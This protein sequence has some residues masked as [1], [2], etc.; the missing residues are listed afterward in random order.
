MDPDFG[1]VGKALESYDRGILAMHQGEPALAVDAFADAIGNDPDRPVLW[2]WEAR[3][4]ITAGRIE[5]AISR[6]NAGL[7]RF[8]DDVVLRYQRAAVLAKS[9]NLPASVQDLRWL[10]ANEKAH[11]I[12]VGEDP[13]F[14]ALKADPL[15]SELVPEAQVDASVTGESGSVLVGERY[16]V[17]FLI[18]SRRG[19]PVHIVNE[20][21][22]LQSMALVRLVEDVTFQDD[23]WTKRML[24]AEFRPL[25]PGR[26]AAGPWM[27]EVGE[28]ATLT[29]RLVID[30]VSIPGQ[31]VPAPAASISMELPTTRWGEMPKP[32]VGQEKDGVWAVVPAG[33]YVTPA[34]IKL[35]PRIEYRVQGQPRWSASL[36]EPDDHAEIRSGAASVYRWKGSTRP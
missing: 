17:E 6:L 10:Y 31:N 32:L 9:G 3:A 11:P 15:Y 25:M 36:I 8:P 16:T 5:E 34:S 14:L 19:T 33:M 28:S 12:E 27:V 26:L 13:S 35:G 21:D 23:I 30:I 1:Q 2:A 29:E 4:L 20:G 7:S 18:T 24:R 22:S